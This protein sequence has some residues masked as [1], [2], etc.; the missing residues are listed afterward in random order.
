MPLTGTYEPSPWPPVA[1][2]VALYESSGGTD[3]LLLEGKPCVILWTTGRK[4]GLVRKSPLMRVTDGER[5]AVVASMGGA[6][7]SPVWYLNLKDDPR[8]TLQ[9]GPIIKD[10]VAREVDGEEKA[11]WWARSTEVWPAYDDYQASTDRVIP[12][13]V[14][15]PV[16]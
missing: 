6:P 3:G 1:D 8:V 16:D 2:H 12:L 7:Q 11:E 10:Y 9:D 4:S 13:V 14:L 15:D 5:Y